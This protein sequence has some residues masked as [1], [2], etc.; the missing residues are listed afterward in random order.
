[1]K[2][3]VFILYSPG[4]NCHIETAEAFRLA[5]ANPEI[6]L[7][8]DDLIRGKKRL[9]ACDLLA[10]PGGFSFGDHLAAGRIFSI[11]MVYRLKDQLI[12]VREKHIPI[13]GICN[14]FQILIN[15]GL[16]PGTAEIGER[17]AIVDRNKSAVFESRWVSL[18]VQETEC[19]WT[20]GLAGRKLDMPVAHGEGR[21]L[22]D[23]SFE[24]SRTVVRYGSMEGVMEYPANP[25]G[26]PGGRAGICDPTGRIF[27]L[28]PHPERAIY[29]WHGSVDGLTIFDAGVGAVK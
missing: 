14:G 28:M 25:N 19:I 26:A 11:D 1:M 22:T 17:T 4:T 3:N 7:L 18:L 13:I 15:T 9:A 16:L 21:F 27:G 24:D 12:E 2:P 29:P 8:T 10:I 6:V 5:G 20:Q 23:A